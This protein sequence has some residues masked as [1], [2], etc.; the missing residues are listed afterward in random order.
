MLLACGP[1]PAAESR[2]GDFLAKVAPGDLIPGAD[3]FG[4]PEGAP[5]VAPVFQ[6]DKLLG[7][8]YLNSDVVDSTGYSGKPIRILV[9]IDTEGRIAGAKLVEHHEPIVLVGIP[10]EK[11]RAVIDHFRGT[12][13]AAIAAGRAE[14][15]R[16]DI[17]SGATVSVLVIADS[18]VRSALKVMQ[19][20]GIGGAAAAATPTTV[21]TI[22]LDR[23]EVVDWQTLLGDGSVRRLHLTVGDVNDAFAR[24]GNEKA[25]ARPEAGQPDDTFIDLYVA[26]ATIPT[27]GRSL[28]GEDGY[29][30]L[31]ARLRPGQQ[32]I[33]VMGDGRY[34]FKG[35]GYVRGGIF[36][37]IELIQGLESV[38]F[39]DRD[40][41]RIG[42]LAADGAPAF[43]EIGLFVLPPDA[44]FDPARQWRLTL[45][46]QRPVGAL[47]KAFLTFELGY[48][49]PEKY[50]KRQAV[51]VETAESAEPATQPAPA[52]AEPQAA[53]A[54]P[55]A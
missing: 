46:V 30:Q 8:A 41:T 14:L 26:L 52:P 51:T 21:A 17:V 36:D 33:L 54:G 18:I 44:R 10:E 3:R 40:H 29:R 12:D 22:D 53:Q 37:R 43:K 20:R 47:E 7:F 49:P 1:A 5:P 42:A 13:V 2:L 34:S 6:G 16:P 11:I 25:A 50:L 39:H 28:L 23:Q 15:P 32:A 55:Q 48:I 45:L 31:T 24:S 4:P 35:S 19:Q 9:A 27:I 38:R